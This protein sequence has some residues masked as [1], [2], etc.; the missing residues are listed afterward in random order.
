[1]QTGTTAVSGTLSSKAVDSWKA[2][3]ACCYEATWLHP[4]V[5]RRYRIPTIMG[6]HV[7]GNLSIAELP[8]ENQRACL[9]AGQ[10]H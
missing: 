8:S 10:M 3:A 9:K 1:M 5:C 7:N 2:H 4:S 6:R